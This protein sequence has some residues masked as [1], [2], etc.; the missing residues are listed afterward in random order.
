MSPT[1]GKLLPHMSTVKSSPLSPLILSFIAGHQILISIEHE[2][3]NKKDSQL[4]V[5]RREV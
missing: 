3:K 1:L 2:K 5:Y 4:A